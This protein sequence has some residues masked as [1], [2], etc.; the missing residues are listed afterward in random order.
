M[1]DARS[2][3]AEKGAVNDIL[4]A[5]LSSVVSKAQKERTAPLDHVNWQGWKIPL[6]SERLKE[7]ILS[8]NNSVS[9][10]NEQRDVVSGQSDPSV[11]EDLYLSTCN[12]HDD[13][14]TIVHDEMVDLSNQG[15]G[16]RVETQRAEL[17]SIGD[18]VLH[19][20]LTIM[21]KW[22]EDLIDKLLAEREVSVRVY[23]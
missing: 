14:T 21:I 11:L 16:S 13:A 1:P 5:R 9:L 22:N 2:L 17:S 18:F 10:L 23:T 15:M 3:L 19:S 20:K 7:A 4:V 12:T 6:R 8:F